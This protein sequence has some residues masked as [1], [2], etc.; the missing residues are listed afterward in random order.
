MYSTFIVLLALLCTGSLFYFFF[1]GIICEYYSNLKIS[2]TLR[3]CN[4]TP[5]DCLLGKL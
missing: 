2:V 4:H 1:L 5:E 3:L